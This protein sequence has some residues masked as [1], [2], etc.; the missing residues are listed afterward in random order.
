LVD[1]GKLR[2]ALKPDAGVA[3]FDL[4]YG[5]ARIGVG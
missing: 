5:G 1:P 4:E 3:R 2:A